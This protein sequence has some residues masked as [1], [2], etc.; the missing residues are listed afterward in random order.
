MEKLGENIKLE[1]KRRKLIT[2][3]VAERAAIDRSTLYK[4]EKGNSSVSIDAYF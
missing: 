1:R 4:I 2:I 3:Q